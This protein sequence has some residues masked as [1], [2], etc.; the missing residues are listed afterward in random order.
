[1]AQYADVIGD[2]ARGQYM[3]LR[4]LDLEGKGWRYGEGKGAPFPNATDKRILEE[5]AKDKPQAVTITDPAGYVD[6]IP[7]EEIPQATSEVLDQATQGVS[8]IDDQGEEWG[9]VLTENGDLLI[10]NLTA[11]DWY[12]R[13]EACICD[14]CRED[15]SHG[16]TLLPIPEEI[17]RD[18]FDPCR[19]H[20][21]E[22]WICEYP[23][24]DLEPM[25]VLEPFDD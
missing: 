24:A 3:P 25:A 19:H 22:C 11:Q 6:T 13:R 23:E 15:D 2:S 20:E 4:L 8:K 14:D 16:Y 12:M 10:L 18:E 21:R 1:M 17:L 5:F 9:L 7:A